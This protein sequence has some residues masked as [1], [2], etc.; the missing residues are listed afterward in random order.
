[1]EKNRRLL[2]FVCICTLLCQLFTPFA[3]AEEG[4]ELPTL[5]L[6]KREITFTVRP[7]PLEW[8]K[9]AQ[10]DFTLSG[11]DVQVLE[12]L[13]DLTELTIEAESSNSDFDVTVLEGSIEFEKDTPEGN[14]TG[15]VTGTL[16]VETDPAA[17]EILIA[18]EG[19]ATYDIT[20]TLNLLLPP[21]ETEPE[22]EPEVIATAD[23]LLTIQAN[24]VDFA[25]VSFSLSPGASELST[26]GEAVV[27]AATIQVSIDIISDEDSRIDHF[28]AESNYS[29]VSCGTPIDSGGSWIF[30]VV[31]DEHSITKNE[32][33]TITVE[34]LDK[35]D[36]VLASQTFTL[37][38]TRNSITPTITL[39]GETVYF[40]EDDALTQTIPLTVYDPDGLIS[41]YDL[42]Y[43]GDDIVTYELDNDENPTTLIITAEDPVTAGTSSV[44]V[45]AK[46]AGDTTLDTAAVTVIIL[47][48]LSAPE[49]ILTD[50]TPET[51]YTDMPAVTVP[52]T[53]TDSNINNLFPDETEI[54]I[55]SVT[56]ACLPE[57]AVTAEVTADGS[58]YMLTITPGDSAVASVEV[59]IT[60]TNSK[61]ISGTESFTFIL[62]AAAAEPAISFGEQCQNTNED[63]PLELDLTDFITNQDVVSALDGTGQY[64]YTLSLPETG[65]EL[66]GGT[67]SLGS[68]GKT[69]TYT[70]ADNYYSPVT[71]VSTVKIPVTLHYTKFGL[72]KTV[73][74]LMEV[75]IVPVED[76]P[77]TTDDTFSCYAD[78]GTYEIL[79]SDL[80]ENDGT[81][82]LD[83]IEFVSLVDG[84]LTHVPE[85]SYA[86]TLKL[87]EDGT[88][89]IYTPNIRYEGVV[90]AQYTIKN[91]TGDYAAAAGFAFVETAVG[92]IT[93]NVNPGDNRL[94]EIT[95]PETDYEITV[96]EDQYVTEETPFTFNI[97]IMDEDVLNW[98]EVEVSLTTDNVN[99]LP[100]GN[101][102]LSLLTPTDENESGLTASLVFL[103][104]AF[105][106]IRYGEL[107]LTLTV[108]DDRNGER[109]VTIPVTVESVN[110]APSLSVVEDSV[111][112]AD[113][114]FSDNVWTMVMAED[115]VTPVSFQVEV[116][117]IDIPLNEDG[118]ADL[119]GYTLDIL[120]FSDTAWKVFAE[121]GVT[122]SAPSVD[123][124]KTVITY[125]VSFS[126]KKDAN[127]HQAAFLEGNI[128][129]KLQATDDQ[130]DKSNEINFTLDVEQVNDNPVA[131]AYTYEIMKN[132]SHT[133]DVLQNCTDVDGNALEITGVTEPSK[134]TAKIVNVELE[135]G[136]TTTKIEYVPTHNAV[137]QDSFKYTISDGKGGTATATVTVNIAYVNY[138][139]EIWANENK[140]PLQGQ[141]DPYIMQEDQT[142]F[143]IELYVEDDERPAG[144]I[145]VGAVLTGSNAGL[146]S[147]VKVTTNGENASIRTLTFTPAA[148]R[149]SYNNGTLVNLVQVTITASDNTNSRTQNIYIYIEPENDA[150]AA[151]NFSG[152][153]KQ[154]EEDGQDFTATSV[155]L[156][157]SDVDAVTGATY[158]GDKISLI[159][160]KFS[161]GD[162]EETINGDGTVTYEHKTKG[163]LTIT[164]DGDGN[165]TAFTY[166]PPDIYFKEDVPLSY[167]VSDTEDK[168]ASAVLTLKAITKNYAPLVTEL[169]EKEVTIWEDTAYKFDLLFMDP[170]T[171]REDLVISIGSSNENVINREGLSYDIFNGDADTPLNY[172]G[173]ANMTI[174]P[175]PNQFCADGEP[176]DITITVS[177]RINSVTTNLKITVRPLPDRPQTP[178]QEYETREATATSFNLLEECLDADPDDTLTLVGVTFTGAMDS[179]GRDYAPASGELPASLGV[180][181]VNENGLCTFT[182][183][184]GFVGELTFTYTVQDS[185][186]GDAYPTY[187]AG[188]PETYYVDGY[189]VGENSGTLTIIVADDS[190]G[191]SLKR[192]QPIVAYAGQEL[193]AYTLETKSLASGLDYSFKVEVSGAVV[194]SSSV[195]IDGESASTDWS[196]TA[197]EIDPTHSISFSLKSGATGKSVI[198]VILVSTDGGVTTENA[199]S[200]TVTTHA[201]NIAPTMLH[202]V[203]IPVEDAV[204]EKKDAGG[205]NSFVIDV[206]TLAEAYD[207]EGEDIRFGTFS[208]SD[209]SDTVS[210]FTDDEDGRQKISYTIGRERN[211]HQNVNG[212]QYVTL[213]YSI[214]DAGGKE[215]E[216]VDEAG[217][218]VLDEGKPCKTAT[219]RIPIKVENHNPSNWGFIR[220]L[221]S[222]TGSY[223]LDRDFWVGSTGDADGETRYIIDVESSDLSNV[224]TTGDTI[225]F[226]ASKTGWVELKYRVVSYPGI[227]V[228]DSLSYAEAV[229]QAGKTGVGAM[230]ASGFATMTLYIPP[231]GGD[232]GLIPPKIAS[233]WARDIEDET[234]IVNS[235]GPRPSTSEIS[236]PT[237]GANTREID[238]TGLMY[239]DGGAGT[240]AN[241][242][243][244]NGAAITSDPNLAAHVINNVRVEKRTQSKA[245]E[246]DPDTYRYYLIYDLLPNGNTYLDTAGNMTSGES[247]ITIKYTMKNASAVDD[248]ANAD[249]SYT[250]YVTP[251]NDKPV[252]HVDGFTVTGYD[253]TKPAVTATLENDKTV[254]TS[255][256]TVEK[257]EVNTIQF[258][259][260]DL[261][262]PTQTLCDKQITILASSGNNMAVVSNAIETIRPTDGTGIWTVRFTGYLV[263]DTVITLRAFDSAGEESETYAQI[264]VNVEGSNTAPTAEDH[265]AVYNEDH[266]AAVKVAYQDIENQ[267]D[268]DGDPVEIELVSGDSNN[269]YSGYGSVKAVG[270][271]IIFTPNQDVCH[272]STW[273]LNS[274]TTTRP[275]DWEDS[276]QIC[277]AFKLKEDTGRSEKLESEVH[278]LYIHLNPINDAPSF[279]GI[280]QTY[281]IKEVSDPETKQTITLTLRDVDSD[282][283]AAFAEHRDSFTCAFAADE[284]G[285]FVSDAA[286]IVSVTK[287]EDT[288][289]YQMDIEL[290]PNAYKSH[291]TGKYSELTVTVV[292]GNEGKNEGTIK[293]H[294]SDSNFAPG[295]IEGISQTDNKNQITVRWDATSE[296]LITNEDEDITIPLTEYFTDPDGDDISLSSCTDAQNGSISIIDDGNSVVF[297]PTDYYYTDRQYADPAEAENLPYW[298]GFKFAVTDGA[299]TVEGMLYIFIRPVNNAPVTNTLAFNVAEDGYLDIALITADSGTTKV[300]DIDN[301]AGELSITAVG[302]VT[303]Q[304]KTEKGGTVE[305]VPVEIDTGGGTTVEKAW[306]LR[307][308]PE[309]DF[310][311]SDSFYYTV[312]DTGNHPLDYW[313]GNG[314]YTDPKDSTGKI[315]I[316]VIG[317]DDP[318]RANFEGSESWDDW[319]ETKDIGLE[320]KQEDINPWVMNED[321]K[322]T[323]KRTFRFAA[324]DVEGRPVTVVSSL[325][326]DTGSPTNC[327]AIT[328]LFDEATGAVPSGSGMDRDF[329]FT[330]KENAYGRVILTVTL[331]DGTE[332]SEYKIPVWVEPVNDEPKITGTTL[333]INED[334]ASPSTKIN[335]TDVETAFANLQFE[336]DES[337][338]A[339]TRGTVAIENGSFVYTPKADYF[340]MDRFWIKVTDLGATNTDDEI[341]SATAEYTV[342]IAP[343]NDAPTAPSNVT[344]DKNQYSG[345]DSVVVTWQIGG[346]KFNETKAADIKYEIQYSFNGTNF[347]TADTVSGDAVSGEEN[348]RS[349]V[350]SGITTGQNTNNLTVRIRTVD[351]G[352]SYEHTGNVAS[353]VVA[354]TEAAGSTSAWAVS[355]GSKVDSTVPSVT[356]TQTPDNWTNGQITIEVKPD[357]GTASGYTQIA[358]VEVLED[359]EYKKIEALGGKYFYT[360]SDNGDYSFRITDE[361]G[362]TFVQEES[363]VHIDRVD[364]VASAE[365]V[366]DSGADMSVAPYFVISVADPATG[367]SGTYPTDGQSGVKTV[368][369]QLLAEDGSITEGG[370]I[371][372]APGDRI[373]IPTRGTFTLH[374]RSADYAGNVNQQSFGPYTIVNTLPVSGGNKSV[375]LYEEEVSGGGTTGITNGTVTFTATDIDNDTLTFSL[376]DD[377]AYQTLLKYAT[378]SIT[379][380]GIV[381]LSHKGGEVPSADAALNLTVNISDGIG[382]ST[383][384]LTVTLVRVNDAPSNPANF[385]ITPAT[386]KAY[387][388]SGASI[389]LTWTQSED[390][391]TVQGDITYELQYRIDSGEWK[392]MPNVT[393]GGSA[394]A[395][396]PAITG[397]G[398]VS[399]QIR[400]NDN[401]TGEINPDGTTAVRYSDWVT[402]GPFQVDNT[403]PTATHTLVQDSSDI[404]Y[405]IVT[406]TAVDGTETWQS[407]VYEIVPPDVGVVAVGVSGNQF[408]VKAD[409]NYV[410]KLVDIAGNERNYS[411]SATAP[412]D[413]VID[414][415]LDPVRINSEIEITWTHDA[416]GLTG[417]IYTLEYSTDG[418]Q[419]IL[420]SS[421]LTEKKYD[422]IVPV[423][424]PDTETL[425]FR[426]SARDDKDLQSP[427]WSVGGKILCDS[428]APV[429]EFEADTTVYTNTDVVV[430]A[431]ITDNLSGI[432]TVTEN[433]TG[434]PTLESGAYPLIFT[435][436]YTFEA[437]RTV[438]VTARD[439]CGNET[440]KSFEVENIDKLVP[441]VAFTASSNG[442]GITTSDQAIN[443]ITFTLDYADTG[444]SKMKTMSY[445]VTNSPDGP[446]DVDFLA[447]ETA[448][449]S[450]TVES[451]AVYYVHIY[452]E[453]HAGNFMYRYEGPYEIVNTAP[454]ANSQE[455]TVYEGGTVTIQLTGSDRDYGDSVVGYSIQAPPGDPLYGSLVE[456]ADGSNDS[457]PGKY[458]YIHDGTQVQNGTQTVTAFE[459]VAVDSYGAKSE[460]ATVTITILP[461]NDPP[462]IED[463]QQFTWHTDASKSFSFDV[464]DADDPFN[465]LRI[466]FQSDNETILPASGIKLV[467]TPDGIDDFKG[468]LELTLTPKL[469]A[470]AEDTTVTVTITVRDSAGLSDTATITLDFVSQPQPPTAADQYFY[471][472]AGAGVTGTV[473]AKRGYKGESLAYSFDA[474][475]V[476]EGVFA[477]EAD[478]SFTYTAKDPFGQDV[479]DKV[480]VTITQTNVDGLPNTVSTITLWFCGEV[481]T[482]EADV[483]DVEV[484]IIPGIT[485]P[486]EEITYTITSTEPDVI[487]AE[488]CSVEY[489]GGK[490]TL[491]YLRNPY[492]Y[493]ELTIT[494]TGSDGSTIELPFV[495]EPINNAPDVTIT[496]TPV[497]TS[498][499]LMSVA[500]TLFAAGDSVTLDEHSPQTQITLITGN[501]LTGTL[502]ALDSNDDQPGN[503]SGKYNGS[504]ECKIFSYSVHNEPLHGSLSL[505]EM[506]GE[507]SYVPDDDYLGEDQFSFLIGEDEGDYDN[508]NPEVLPVGVLDLSGGTEPKLGRV[509][510]VILSIVEEELLSDGTVE[511]VFADSHDA[512]IIGYPDGTVRPGGSLIRAEAATVF[513]RLLK[514]EVRDANWTQSNSYSDVS[515]SDWHN[516]AVSVMSAMGIL[517]GHTDGKFRPG[518]TITR[519]ELAAIAARFGR[520]QGNEAI[521]SLSFSDIDGHW[522]Y[523]DIIYATSIGWLDGY[524]DGS[525][526][527]DALITRAEFMALV[528]RMTGRNPENEDDLLDGMITWPDNMDKNAWYYLAV[529]EAT[530]SHKHQKKNVPDPVRGT[531]YER[532]LVVTDPR[533]WAAL[534]K[535]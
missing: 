63:T 344:L 100:Q 420:I 41:S 262:F 44:T 266:Q 282:L 511:S 351:D 88:K 183:E 200:F 10:V 118:S 317:E 129:F 355:G 533:D 142:D 472:Q 29:Y 12:E 309:H 48:A 218:K 161:E 231:S 300:T 244:V 272:T 203:T 65:Q 64:D 108:T 459:F 174:T 151:N 288:N 216:A 473:N 278:Y 419:W 372:H 260:T 462:E 91:K 83:G 273:A 105:S 448:S 307:Y 325:T 22:I 305:I 394:S 113:L 398:T 197:T 393:G 456:A 92:T 366:P 104:D 49:V 8:A 283:A 401:N 460:T 508:G 515:V 220:I 238:I 43:T 114:T 178:A 52:F 310:A 411:V 141:G 450:V 343:V 241:L 405:A 499:A 313:D 27:S 69:L 269:S 135:G 93:I 413:P 31:V 349:Y 376:V 365:T 229:E 469:N 131:A 391:E 17:M 523:S 198:R 225:S 371:T 484:R 137:G 299:A 289:T 526:R 254:I 189:Y 249:G 452:A 427:S 347:T 270:D 68:D 232:G 70:P 335:A 111:S 308:T 381:N 486:A 402:I 507:Y 180:M 206:L 410:F 154:G 392:P 474:S 143:T 432:A 478:G 531:F 445:V 213:T 449:I 110:D 207:I 530:N 188:A 490:L 321:E 395:D 324:W 219:I 38:L 415:D 378:V 514:D 230:E 228:S 418:E 96:N 363:V 479:E 90:T 434:T 442:S 170:E 284:T 277:I 130:G 123:E 414:Y 352:K 132:I 193:P 181:T 519:G 248:S 386:A 36:E 342:N 377:A 14:L 471:L 94:P 107:E 250:I 195:K 417:I 28:I 328:D 506:T 76:A 185:Y 3:W 122:V 18:G 444:V 60:A 361:V 158:E 263:G 387:Y 331:S 465:S 359:S 513:F 252:M 205:Y 184:D 495:V 354:K 389:N 477:G 160:L 255:E 364:P 341:L 525:F 234:G 84:S 199:M 210:V 440:T 2:A 227:L 275:G 223:T 501:S 298:G 82:E 117:D 345:I 433:M 45:T 51:L 145:T 406:I 240:N 71:D 518:A 150:P 259:V 115:P 215:G 102:E 492:M 128:T 265:Y 267:S 116:T 212:V 138:P 425:Q 164:K 407:G 26:S 348:L 177:D 292:D 290:S 357:P 481:R 295:L 510:T 191:P 316:T 421:S 489:A 516:N 214:F 25:A 504:Y 323:A 534:E 458:T 446:A 385:Q 276:E 333:N 358:K 430:T 256:L 476:T 47:E 493:G 61:G 464:T 382:V 247:G 175:R 20:I 89:L 11:L 326:L 233:S 67:V 21:E 327:A 99:I 286:T 315:N 451:I 127:T 367:D 124:S 409:A 334:A 340:G 149:N 194:D 95:L 431:K 53:V 502:S 119:S 362:N 350:L 163:T 291:S 368:K 447:A 173:G 159:G 483:N 497:S 535:R 75:Y 373:Y 423:G 42:D 1:M 237:S 336:L 242:E 153:Y 264:T 500:A 524:T 15:T 40:R 134:G 97:K 168:K 369:I 50:T 261:D 98:S 498:M 33:A 384:T 167:T 58:G 73:S 466:T 319:Y 330:P 171:P 80:L 517:T 179:D 74:A 147:D 494:L 6:D 109:I 190:I 257:D 268:P 146:I 443:P 186:H 436:Y 120:D 496:S 527:P 30:S 520:L 279:V 379:D 112:G 338:P 78:C 85:N 37:T 422:F 522:A 7:E 176:I 62:E 312:T 287:V 399:Y 482:P 339:P 429:I 126:P 416:N 322:E 435:T 281:E 133:W 182:P 148:N 301:P 441:T 297:D 106:G 243:F 439:L 4:D 400:A 353:E 196:Y 245:Q 16:V 403:A 412:N 13:T 79:I 251:V 306:S 139:P 390:L 475:G 81:V 56:A 211:V 296:W 294:V 103:P 428:T 374:V 236:S 19:Y 491:M 383:A 463:D 346:D 224:T 201:D 285:V 187:P 192:L 221:D 461:V 156:H 222:N 204:N 239:G 314:N 35:D 356:F 480:K 455:V 121:N 172:T 388:Q 246:E 293:V 453:D 337:K 470:V 5:D 39:S 485:Q 529:Q 59:T 55:T 77:E 438:T 209:S 318:P 424:T 208:T 202:N 360:V 311:G 454:K 169:E 503:S 72:S 23:A 375:T 370:W 408:R 303:V 46:G 125:T 57:G 512:Y 528:N 397:G 140:T 505:D 54:T 426:V 396:I 271:Q 235:N 32:T 24:F 487:S 437:N 165:I 226:T 136:G 320:L 155:L 217:N 488:N 157:C 162:V 467:R 509:V 304:G 521:R 87:S 404:E 302:T 144:S 101:I 166:L 86:G 152:S 329:T 66:Q 253:E 34:A 468:E 332:D 280:G 9:S 532:W 380:S 457:I 274:G 258:K